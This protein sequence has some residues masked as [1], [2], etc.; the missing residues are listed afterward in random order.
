MQSPRCSTVFTDDNRP[1][2][3]PI[4]LRNAVL[5]KLNLTGSTFSGSDSVLQKKV[6]AHEMGHALKLKHPWHS[7]YS[8]SA[9]TGDDK[10]GNH[11]VLSI[12]NQNATII[13]HITYAGPSVHDIYF[14]RMKW[15][16]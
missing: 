8:G 7:G 3:P 5:I 6:I 16:D 9:G 14:L 11:S 13:T 4:S 1:F 15:G 12:M 2:T 10:P